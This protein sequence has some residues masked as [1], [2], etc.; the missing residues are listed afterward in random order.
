MILRITNNNLFIL[1]FLL[2]LALEVTGVS[3]YSVISFENNHVPIYDGVMYDYKQ[4]KR[5]ES[6]H[7]DFSLLNR[8]NQSIYEYR[9]NPISGVYSAFLTFVSPT[10]LVSKWDIFIRSFIGVYLFSISFYFYFKNYLH[11]KW[12]LLLLALLFQLPYFYHYR[13]GLGSSVPELISAI[14]LMSGFLFILSGIDRINEKYISSGLL[15]M[16]FSVLFR[17]NFFVYLVL[18]SFPLFFYLFFAWRSFLIFQRKRILWSLAFF[19]LVFILYVSLYF[20]SFINY[21][22]KGA[23]AFTTL[24]LSLNFMLS[25]FKDYINYEGILI[26]ILILYGNLVFKRVVPFG[27]LQNIYPLL[28]PFVI[29]FSFIILYLKST[30]V[31]H[32]M[33]IM[34]FLLTLAFVSLK[35]NFNYFSIYKRINLFMLGLVVVCLVFFNLYSIRSQHPID[36]YISQKKV[37]SYLEYKLRKN[38]TL[39]FSCFYDS[40]IEIPIINALYVKSHILYSF[41]SVFNVQDIFYPKSIDFHFN[42]IVATLSDV[43][44]VIINATSKNKIQIG[45]KA[46]VIQNKVRSFLQTH[47]K[48]RLRKIIPSSYYSDLYIFEFIK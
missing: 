18:L 39:K 33:S 20:S 4:I 9:G 28:L 32:I 21:Y 36:Q 15:I 16:F 5:Y 3:L 23:Y 44:I 26:F 29:F 14:Y 17:F 34:V 48:Y 7:D 40:D 10:F 6:F 38:P 22:T 43:D 35:F 31:P 24:S 46:L 1:F 25:V 27:K 8:F 45:R 12:V 13:T 37:V 47:S 42:E 11:K 2:F 41:Q 19:F 30:N